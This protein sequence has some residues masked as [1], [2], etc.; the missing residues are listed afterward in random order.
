[1]LTVFKQPNNLARIYYFLYFAAVGSF[2]PYL[3]LYYLE[4]GLDTIQIGIIVATLTS[5]SLVANP[6]WNAIADRFQLHHRLLPVLIWGT[7]PLIWLL[8][9]AQD[10]TSLMV[11]I[12]LYAMIAA[13]IVPMADHA[14]LTQLGEKRQEYGKLRLWGSLGFGIFSY[15]MGH[16]IEAFG[17]NIGF[18]AYMVVVIVAGWVANQLPKA[19]IQ[20]TEPFWKSMH[21]FM[22][23][24]RF[25]RF[26]L[27]MLLFG[28][29]LQMLG[30]Y[31]PLYLKEL[32]AGEGLYGTAVAMM[33]ISEL[34]ILFFA[35]L[36]LRKFSSR[37]LITVAFVILI[38]RCFLYSLVQDPHIAVLIQGSQGLSFGILLAAGVNYVSDMAPAGLGASAQGLYAA[39]LYSL[40]GVFGALVGS[41]LYELIGAT[42]MFSVAGLLVIVGMMIFIANEWELPS[43]T[44]R[45]PL[46]LVRSRR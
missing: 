24:K 44:R 7:L 20:N 42:G 11:S 6:V 9:H 46:Q 8:A 18:I 22:G 45:R 21:K 5:I 43:V 4:V 19:A 32:G 41:R 14:V 30:N 38:V 16:L 28:I 23:H 36:L 2:G 39:V 3:N 25:W 15:T 27:S 34:P 29:A 26:L 1:M 35:P 33:G 40:S 10:F 13:P 31:F 17:M 12:S 37:S